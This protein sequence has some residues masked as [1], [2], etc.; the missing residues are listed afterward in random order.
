LI[1]ASEICDNSRNSCPAILFRTSHANLQK[2]PE[3]WFPVPLEMCMK[4]NC[5]LNR[6]RLLSR[7]RTIFCALAILGVPLVFPSSA[8]DRP[9]RAAGTPEPASGEFFPCF[10]YAGP[11]RQ[12]GE[13]WIITFNISGSSTGTFTSTSTGITGTELD[14]VH[15]DGSITLHGTVLFTGSVNGRSG[16]LLFTYEGIGNGVTGHEDLRFVGRQGTGDLAGVY[17]ELAAEGDVGAPE[18]GCDLSGAGTY[19]G[20]VLF[21]R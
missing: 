17:A 4:T 20:H 19:T 7:L 6:N 9:G 16:T 14:V 5:W 11:P 1:Q 10:T 12:V 13:N 21:V 8:A 2:I 18:P 15:R 3:L